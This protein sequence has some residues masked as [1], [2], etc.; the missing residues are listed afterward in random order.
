MATLVSIRK[1]DQANNKHIY[2]VNAA[3]IKPFYI[4]IDPEPRHIGYYTD[5]T[6][7]K[8][9]T[10]ID[11]NEE[12]KLLFKSIPKHTALLTLCR[13]RKAIKENQFPEVL[14]FCSEPT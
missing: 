12:C 6:L 13:A 10:T 7:N 9:V 1:I 11:L 4:T 8:H 3:E 5:K 2:E 14:D